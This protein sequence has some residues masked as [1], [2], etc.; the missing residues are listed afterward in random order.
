MGALRVGK[1][2]THKVERTSYIF[3]KDLFI[4]Y[5]CE[6]TEAVQMFVTIAHLAPGPTHFG[7]DHRAYLL[8]CVSTL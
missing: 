6:Y 7:P 1:R 2:R 4:F 3:F 5:V 8:L